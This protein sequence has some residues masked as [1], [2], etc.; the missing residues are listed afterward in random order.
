MAG[1]RSP[2]SGNVTDAGS[3]GNYWSSDVNGNVSRDLR[4]TSE[5]EAIENGVRADAISVRCIKN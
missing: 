2:T 3:F 1:W 5:G 4:F